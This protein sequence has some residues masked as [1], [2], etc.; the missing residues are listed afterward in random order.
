MIKF[1][2][3]KG[4]FN[5][6]VRACCYE[7]LSLKLMLELELEMWSP[8]LGLAVRNLAHH[9][10]SAKQYCSLQDDVGMFDI[11]GSTPGRET[12]SDYNYMLQTDGTT[13]I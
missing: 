9:H 7:L 13:K 4:K 2:L 10:P 11:D 3:A 5:D 1:K 8:S 6:D 12:H